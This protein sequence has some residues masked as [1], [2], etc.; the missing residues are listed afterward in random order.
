MQKKGYSKEN[1]NYHVLILEDEN[2]SCIG[3]SAPPGSV[4]YERV[5]FHQYETEFSESV[6]MWLKNHNA[7]NV[8]FEEDK[9]IEWD[10]FLMHFRGIATKY[11]D[12]Y[13]AWFCFLRQQKVE[14]MGK[15]KENIACDLWALINVTERTASNRRR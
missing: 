5:G 8:R 1:S 10:E 6:S 13:V 9:L 3:I 11:L 15:T 12:K 7:A 2:G 4:K 14:V